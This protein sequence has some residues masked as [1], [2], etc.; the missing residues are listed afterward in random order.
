[1]ITFDTVL[2]IALGREGRER[3]TERERERER[4][5]GREGGNRSLDKSN[6][7][8]RGAEVWERYFPIIV[9]SYVNH[10]SQSK[11]SMKLETRK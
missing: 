3:G 5:R 2:H 7:S 10:S 6:V 8:S 1:M 9:F 4:E 11:D